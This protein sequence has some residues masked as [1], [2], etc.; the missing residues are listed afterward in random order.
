M[1][2]LS[3]CK[4]THIIELFHGH[5]KKTDYKLFKAVLGKWVVIQFSPHRYKGQD[6]IGDDISEIIKKN[7]DLLSRLGTCFFH[8][9]DITSSNIASLLLE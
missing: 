4:L 3:S 2:L 8:S 5:P 6:G 9:F 7:N 1:A